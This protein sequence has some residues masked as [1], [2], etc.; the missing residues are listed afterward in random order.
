MALRD[1]YLMSLLLAYSA[2]HRARLLQH[3]EPATRIA[4]WVQD[5]FP[6]L[7]HALNDPMKVMS[8]TSLASAIMLA[9]LE[10]ISPKAFGVEVPWRLHLDTARQ[11]IAAR[12]GWRTM[13]RDHSPVTDFLLRWFAYLDVLGSLVG[14]STDPP[15][16]NVAVGTEY[17]MDETHDEYRIDCLFGFTGR[18]ITILASIAA[19]AHGC[20]AD[21]IGPDHSIRSDW[22]PSEKIREQAEMLI[23]DT[24]DAMLK[25]RF[26]P[27]P[28]LHSLG[29]ATDQWDHL[30]MAAVNEA[31]HWAGLVHL[32]RR[33]LGKHSDHP[34]IQKAVGAIFSVLLK[35]KR[36]STAEACLLF[37]MFTAGCDTQ[38]MRQRAIILDRLLNVE[39]FGM[40]QVG[41][42][43][44][45]A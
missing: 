3:P 9:S 10:I 45:H 34:D 22:E 37:P 41:Q 32:H 12:G 30:Q 29:E 23:L 36:G 19:L 27:C 7:R 11:V 15:S 40:S 17:H 28:H 5:I 16:I 25:T 13:N 33:V 44:S 24:E 14:G 8:L 38:D 18:C 42:C 31:Y 20:A 4:L 21:R 39:Q 43:T 1:T 35:I 2:S 26:K 6:N